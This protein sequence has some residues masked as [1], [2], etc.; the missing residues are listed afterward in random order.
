MKTPLFH[1]KSDHFS[2]NKKDGIIKRSPF[3]SKEYAEA[4]STVR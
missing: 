4:I 1:L 2:R 3:L